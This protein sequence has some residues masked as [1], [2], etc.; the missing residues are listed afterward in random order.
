M[1]TLINTSLRE[2]DVWHHEESPGKDIGERAAHLQ[3]KTPKVLEMP[4][5]WDDYQEQ[6]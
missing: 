6:Q 1:K 4:I 5:P 2:V 3:D